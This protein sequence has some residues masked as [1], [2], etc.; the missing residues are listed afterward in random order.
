MQ[1]EDFSL[2]E[3]VEHTPLLDMGDCGINASVEIIDDEIQ[4]DAEDEEI[5]VPNRLK[6]FYFNETKCE[7]KGCYGIAVHHCADGTLYW[8][9]CGRVFCKDHARGTCTEPGFE[10]LAF[11]CAECY[12][13]FRSE[14][15][16]WKCYS[17]C[18]LFM[19]VITIIVIFKLSTMDDPSSL[20]SFSHS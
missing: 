14:A 18:S 4:P 11:L 7:F 20:L 13:R 10:E 9:G 17:M 1:E 8:E 2:S 19:L 15:L 5:P 12:A 6:D 16:T 3:P